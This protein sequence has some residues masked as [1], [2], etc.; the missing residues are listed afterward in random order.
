MKI[1]FIVYH[2]IQMQ[3][4]MS[5]YSALKNDFDCNWVVGPFKE[6]NLSEIAILVDHSQYHRLRKSKKGYQY[7]FYLSHDMCDTELYAIEDLKNFDL[8]FTPTLLHYKSALSNGYTA[9]QLRI[10]GWP[11]YDFI[12]KKKNLSELNITKKNK[13]KTVLYAPSILNYNWKLLLKFF[14]NLNYNVLIK[15]HIIVDENTPLQIGEEDELKKHLILA[16]KLERVSENLG[17]TVLPRNLN[18][19]E[20]FPYVDIFFSDHRSSTLAEFLPFGVAIDVCDD[21]YDIKKSILSDSVINFS[22]SKLI[23]LKI[24]DFKK[25]IN[26][27]KSKKKNLLIRYNKRENVGKK[28]AKIIKNYIKINPPKIPSIYQF[29]FQKIKKKYFSEFKLY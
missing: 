24:S 6:K 12:N 18:I 10:V 28:I 11:K 9:D 14:R 26:S 22:P 7:L 5:V 21:D 19:C 29:F 16:N 17:F 25:I 4:A 20:V 2:S 13:K 3:S 1:D 23:S 27:Q 15:N 8:I